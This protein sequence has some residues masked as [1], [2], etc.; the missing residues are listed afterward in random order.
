MRL[1]DF[2]RPKSGAT[3]KSGVPRDTVEPIFAVPISARKIDPAGD[4][5]G[6]RYVFYSF[7]FAPTADEAVVRLRKELRDEGLELIELTGQ[8]MATSIPEW[9]DFVAAQFDM[10]QRSLPTAKQLAE[11]SRAIVYYTP[12]IIQY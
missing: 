6:T 12:K 3:A 4:N 8:V 7:L 11:G 10:F 2:L 1:F 9:T 5:P